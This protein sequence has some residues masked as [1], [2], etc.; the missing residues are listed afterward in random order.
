MTRPLRDLPGPVDPS[1]D[2]TPDT[3]LAA[4]LRGG[5][6]QAALVAFGRARVFVGI[7]PEPVAIDARTGADRETDLALVTLRAPSGAS[8]VPAFTG[9]TTL[10]GWRAAAR[11][12]PVTGADLCAEARRLGHDAVVLDLGSSTSVTIDGE[13]L[14]AVAAGAAVPPAPLV[15]SA[16]LVPS[17]PPGADPGPDLGIRPPRAGSGPSAPVRRALV[18][19]LRPRAATVALWPAEI[20][21][22]HSRGS[23]RPALIAA[24]APG[25]PGPGTPG[26]DP[27]GA[28][29]ETV[30]EVVTRALTEAVTGPRRLR[31]RSAPAPELVVVDWSRAGGLRALLGPDLLAGDRPG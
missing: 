7:E 26:P 24:L 9:V 23:G 28:V 5:D 27:T 22:E 25:S 10:T 11:P 8:A 19:A 1:D 21:D 29:T 12:V 18:R 17:A 3:R 4:A 14:A 30:A 15:S 20:E 6:R 16:P 31:R 2:G 13:E